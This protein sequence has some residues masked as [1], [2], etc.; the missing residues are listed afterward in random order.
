MLQNVPVFD[1]DTHYAEPPDLWTKR[2]PSKFA[3]KVLHVRVKPDGDEA[4]FIG[5]RQVALIGPSVIDSKMEKCYAI[6]TIQT[7]ESMSRAASF[8]KERLA[9]MDSY[10]CGRQIIYPNVIGFGTQNL[11][12]MSQ[13]PAL[14]KWHV[15]AYNDAMA[16]LQREGEGR[17]LPQAALPLWD[18]EASLK[19]LERIRKMGL[20]GVVM[21]DKPGDFGQP[22][23][24]HPMWD[25]L[26][27]A[28]QDL[29]L[30][31]N[32]HVASGSF[33]GDLGKWWSDDR[34]FIRKDGSLNGPLAAFASAQCFLQN[35]ADI[36]NLI[37]QGTLEKY[38]RLKFVSVESGCGWLPFAILAIEHNFREMVGARD[39]SRFKRTP[40]EMF[41]EQVY[42]SYWFENSNCVDS[43][44]KEFGNG[45]LMFETDFPHPCSLY[46]DIRGKIQETLGH[47][48]RETQEKVLYRNAEQVYGVSVH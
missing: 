29:M 35:F 34:S 44:L 40:K 1:I 46:P 30:P 22:P 25:P 39:G 21:S 47:H 7:F 26:F 33:E 2:A 20:T 5:E 24:S 4:W 3:N 27:A 10:G 12:K 37:L 13:D 19:E 41:L 48:D 28:C 42:V 45:N 9:F 23:L 18:I 14:R 6:P 15:E 31:I 38:H 8:A 16:D 32:F 36:G 43:Y 11:M 17:L